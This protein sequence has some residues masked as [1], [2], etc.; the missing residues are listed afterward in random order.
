MRTRNFQE[1]YDFCRLDATYRAYHNLPEWAHEYPSR[2]KY[3]YY[4]R[5]FE[6]RGLSR[7]G[8]YLFYQAEK[9]LL[10]F[11][12][13]KTSYVPTVHAKMVYTDRGLVEIEKYHD[14]IYLSDCLHISMR[15]TNKGYQITFSN[16]FNGFDDVVFYARSHRPANK[17]GM[18][19]E[20]IAYCDKHLFLAP[21]RYRDLQ[22]RYRVPKE[23]F[24]RWYKRYKR[25]QH[26]AYEDEHYQMLQEYKQKERGFID[27]DECRELL[28]ATGMLYDITSDEYEQ[29]ELVEEFYQM[30]NYAPSFQ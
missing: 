24:V 12:G 22:L 6:P 3:D 17:E 1:V 15:I 2:K 13:V 11:M 25:E 29:E 18:I 7:A 14:D 19:Q 8:S 21:G 23:N 27:Y 10:R 9:Q 5:S 30:V 26:E 16:P 4:H 20:V 28:A